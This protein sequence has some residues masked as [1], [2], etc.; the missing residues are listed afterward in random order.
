V[1]TLIVEDDPASAMI[2]QAIL[3]R[4]GDCRIAEN[5]LDGVKAVH[6]AY[7]ANRPFDLICLDLTM[8]V[9]DGQTALEEI[10][11]IETDHDIPPLRRARIVMTTASADKEAVIRA[12]RARCDGYLAK[13]VQ[14]SRLLEELHR[15]KLM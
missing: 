1:R 15:L 4:Y 14:K 7:K 8:P 9:M 12:I 10:R 6:E 13:P 2:L 5:G 3:A 11:I